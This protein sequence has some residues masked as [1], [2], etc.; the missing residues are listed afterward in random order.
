MSRARLRVRV[1]G[2]VFGLAGCVLTVRLFELQVLAHHDWCARRDANPRALEWLAAA[3]GRVEDRAGR[4]LAQDEFQF[5]LHLV[6]RSFRRAHP[7]GLLLHLDRYVRDLGGAFGQAPPVILQG[8][9][10]RYGGAAGRYHAALDGALGMPARW[11]HR[12]GPLPKRLRGVLRFYVFRCFQ[13]APSPGRARLRSMDRLGLA[14]DER[15]TAPPRGSVLD[16]LTEVLTGD[17]AAAARVQARAHAWLREGLADLARLTALLGGR[18]VLPGT[19]TEGAPRRG[20]LPAFL[21]ALDSYLE[22][23]A[24]RAFEKVRREAAAARARTFWQRLADWF[25]GSSARVELGFEGRLDLRFRFD[26]ARFVIAVGVPFD[27]VA[28]LVVG[29]RERYPGFELGERV[30]RAYPRRNARGRPYRLLGLVRERTESPP[31]PPRVP[32]LTASGELDGPVDLARR[33]N[34]EDPEWLRWREDLV[35]QAKRDGR[36]RRRKGISGVEFALDAVLRGDR[37]VRELLRDRHGR[38]RNSPR[39]VP[40]LRG[41]DVRL[42]VD[43]DLQ[44]IA[45][46]SLHWAARELG[47]RNPALRLDEVHASFTLIDAIRGDIYA[48]AWLPESYVLPSGEEMPFG[49]NT[50]ARFRYAPYP[51]S[52][53]KPLFALEGLLRGVARAPGFEPCTGRCRGVSCDCRRPRE[54]NVVTA[55]EYSCNSW[56]VQLGERLGGGGLVRALQR[57]ALWKTPADV[58][59]LRIDT[60]GPVPRERRSLPQSSIGYGIRIPPLLIARAYA[61]IATGSLPPLRYVERVGGSELPPTGGADL[62]LDGRVLAVVR[63]GLRRVPLAAGTARSAGLAE[64]A[65]AGKTGTAEVR[66]K[67]ANNVWFAG[68]LPH[69]R[70]RLAFA[71]VYWAAPQGVHG[72]H[73]AA[74]A[75]AECLRRM[76]QQGLLER[77]LGRG[78]R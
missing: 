65:V 26:H 11:L 61:G 12:A 75:V 47:E 29:R 69:D 72:S 48:M 77:Y 6:Y 42:T 41:L 66:R 13:A 38:E 19:G 30:R 5:V 57:F 70:P 55:L 40:A 56:F 54:V 7:A 27:S 1:L 67:R 78:D 53:V 31:T 14:F 35:E 34:V 24:D 33:V 62:G 20:D 10:L 68:Y 76:R 25:R 63:E 51:G 3:R 43:A 18:L 44:D 2:V 58:Q 36:F 8:G 50:T 37:G 74:I 16:A 39:Y 71:C 22:R 49:T 28:A 21:D 52:V 17:P 46:G 32:L 45:V 73:L 64:F 9:P 4:A 60:P 15:W 23:R 59:G